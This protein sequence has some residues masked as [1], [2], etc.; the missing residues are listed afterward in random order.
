[1]ARNVTAE[2]LELL[3]GTD[4]VPADFTDEEWAE[5]EEEARMRREDIPFSGCVKY[6]LFMEV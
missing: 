6:S 3:E 4:L 5:V 1:M 2:A